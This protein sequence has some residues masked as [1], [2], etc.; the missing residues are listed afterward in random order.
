M[1]L[2]QRRVI[3]A[4][5]QGQVREARRHVAEGVVEQPLPGRV[6][7][8]VLAAHHVGHP[9]QPIVDHDGEVVGRP[10]FRSE[11]HEVADDVGVP[12]DAA[13][14]AI[15]EDD[16]AT[17]GHTETDGRRLARG[18]T[19]FRLGAGN[20]A[21][22]SRVFRRQRVDLLVLAIALEFSGVQKQKYAWPSSRRRRAW[23][24]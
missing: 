23:S 22:A 10:A 16:L 20:L 21:A 1:P 8:V 15:V 13:A 14:H 12:G 6:R 19:P 5:H 2:R 9:H 7:H 4:H 11:D 18:A 17:G 24:A 3:G